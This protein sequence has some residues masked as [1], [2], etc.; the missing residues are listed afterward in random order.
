MWSCYVT[1]ITWDHHVKKG[2]LF[3]N[4]RE[5]IMFF[6]SILWCYLCKNCLSL[7]TCLLTIAW[8]LVFLICWISAWL[9]QWIRISQCNFTRSDHWLWWKDNAFLRAYM[10][11]KNALSYP[12]NVQ[13]TNAVDWHI[14]FKST[15][16]PTAK[17][18][19]Q[20]LRAWLAPM[21]NITVR[22]PVAECHATWADMIGFITENPILLGSMA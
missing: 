20:R 12:L 19:V 16:Q 2:N 10:A 11:R 17:T 1:L 21:K 5:P 6:L 3:L 22:L 13:S 15:H 4:F 7:S 14:L 8:I 9:L 18:P